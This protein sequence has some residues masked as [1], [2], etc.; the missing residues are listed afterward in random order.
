MYTFIS[1]VQYFLQNH[2]HKIITITLNIKW[3]ILVQ[4]KILIKFIIRSLRVNQITQHRAFFFV[5]F[6]LKMIKIKVIVLQ[7][8]IEPG[9][10]CQQSILPV[11]QYTWRTIGNY[12]NRL[13]NPGCAKIYTPKLYLSRRFHNVEKLWFFVRR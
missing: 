13:Y 4:C 8:Q 3:Y 7:L 11:I 2:N 6:G 5:D 1:F 10:M 12:P 9:V